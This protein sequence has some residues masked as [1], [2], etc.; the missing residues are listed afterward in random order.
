MQRNLQNFLCL[1]LACP[2]I[3]CST[4]SVSDL[5]SR[6][7][8]DSINSPIQK[9]SGK[10]SEVQE[11][12]A[13]P[14]AKTL[15]FDG[16]EIV[17]GQ[18]EHQG[19]DPS[20]WEEQVR[21]FID[22]GKSFSARQIILQHRELSERIL[23]ERWASQPQDPLMLRLAS[24]LSN[25][26][27]QDDTNWSALLQIAQ[28]QNSD[29][30]RDY[31]ALRSAFASELQED[32][33]SNGSAEE[34]LK[35]SVQV[36]HPLIKIDALR[37]IGLR[38]LVAGRYAWSQ[39]HFR[40]AI[41]IAQSSGHPQLAAQLWLLV[42]ESARR[43]EQ[44]DLAQTAWSD[45]IKLHLD[46]DQ[47]EQP[48]DVGFWLLADKTRPASGK[49]PD[50]L[51]K[52]WAKRL[53][54]L[55]CNATASTEVTLWASIAHAQFERGE[56]QAALVNFKKA[57]TQADGSNAMWLRIAQ[58]K[59]LAGMSQAP[60]ASAILSGPAASTDK[61]ISAAATAMMGGIKLQAGAYKQ[62]AHLLQKAL[63]DASATDWPGRNKSLADLAI[64]Q[65][66]I[67]D[68]EVGLI[69]LHEAQTALDNSKQRS[70]LIDSLENEL[71]LLEFEGRTADCQRIKGNLHRL[72]QL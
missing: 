32:D 62:G 60:A 1:L 15:R 29:L 46:H 58:A 71:R 31:L 17:L 33:P 16:H 48:L 20:E 67:G 21:R 7:L 39:S 13:N 26:D 12:V 18:S 68:T 52:Y 56:L 49:W 27:A 72:E 8:I 57:E 19:V 2:A 9:L 64:A 45:A 24:T 40:Q 14:P 35:A 22:Q 5:T 63:T 30:T 4:L 34:L 69:A 42:A 66:I 51:A 41:E 47:I 10:N 25:R 50:V 65:L 55:G 44:Y 36:G 37:L 70:V 3:G 11:T 28:E 61:N 43:N 23:I 6:N 38:D 54:T 53:Q 59:C